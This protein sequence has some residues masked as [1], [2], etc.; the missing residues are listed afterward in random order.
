LP[1]S[2][3]TQTRRRYPVLYFLHGYG[4]TAEAYVRS[5]QIPETIDRAG[6]AGAGEM[7][8]VDGRWTDA[9]EA[10]F[11]LWLRQNIDRLPVARPQIEEIL[12]QR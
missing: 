10:D 5:L 12:K 3:A 2:Y 8:V 6:A 7:I 1:A 9:I 11:T 4:A